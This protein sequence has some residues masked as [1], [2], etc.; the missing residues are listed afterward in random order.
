M[1]RMEQLSKIYRTGFVETRALSEFSAHVEAGGGK[2][3]GGLVS[4]AGTSRDAVEAADRACLQ[5]HQGGARR[6]E[7]QDGCVETAEVLP[8]DRAPLPRVDCPTP[9]R[10]GSTGPLDQW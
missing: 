4:F 1:L 7:I 5:C 6:F 9:H 10:L 2:G 8:G 3:V